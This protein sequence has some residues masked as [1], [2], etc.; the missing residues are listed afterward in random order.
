[1]K[2]R[3]R[4]RKPRAAKSRTIGEAPASSEVPK[5]A[6]GGDKAALPGRAI[7]PDRPD[8]PPIG[9]R[10]IPGKELKLSP[11]STFSKVLREELR[12][13]A[14]RRGLL[15][16]RDKDDDAKTAA[17][18]LTVEPESTAVL[19]NEDVS[20]KKARL[21]ALKGHVTGLSFSGGGIRAGTFAVGF[22]Q[23]LASL[24]LVRRLDYLSTVSGGGYAGA[25]LAA[26]LKR[27]GGDP[28]KV[29]RQLSTSRVDQARADRTLLAEDEVVEEEPQTLRH[30][31]SYSSYMIPQPGVFSVD[32][33]TIILI[34][35]R[36]VSINLLVLLPMAMLLVFLA[37]LAVH[38]FVHFDPV[39]YDVGPAYRWSAVALLAA[40]FLLLLM[41]LSVNAIQLREF[42]RSG[43]GTPGS[44]D[45]S[46][47]WRLVVRLESLL[48]RS[49]GSGDPAGSG[50]RARVASVIQWFVI[51]PG[52][53]AALL[54]T[55]TLR[56][57]VWAVGDSVSGPQL[58]PDPQLRFSIE[59]VIGDALRANLDI[60][61][62]S[63]F[64]LHAVVLGGFLAMGAA[65]GASEHLG[66]RRGIVVK[67]AL[68]GAALTLSLVIAHELIRLFGSPGWLVVD[69]IGGLPGWLVLGLPLVPLL[70]AMVVLGRRGRRF[71]EA[72]AAGGA[73]AGILLVLMEAWIKH[74][75]SIGR[76][77]LMATI[78][79]PLT[80]L[81]AVAALIVQVALLGRVIGES[82]RE[83]WA[84]IS[85]RLT[86]VAL[87]WLG[88]M[89][90]IIYLPGLLL[91]SGPAIRALIASGWLATAVVGVF[92]GRYALPKAE[93]DAA[94]RLTQLGSIAAQAFLVGLLGTVALVGSILLNMPGLFAPR[95]DALGPFA[96]YMEGVKGTSM[97]ALILLGLGSLILYLIARELID[98][99]LFSLNAMYANRLTR[100]YLGA[101]RPM[102][103]WKG[104][105]GGPRRD[106][107]APAGAPSLSVEAAASM[108]VRETNPIT[109]FDMEDDLDLGHLRIGRRTGPEQPYYGP[110]L[111]IN[112]T[113]NLVGSD[114]LAT[115]DRK[116]E[117]FTLSPLYCGSKG[118]GYAKLDESRR[119]EEVD[120]QLT[121]GRAIAISGAAVDPN[122]SFYQSAPL[123]ALLTL[124]NA[125]LGYWIEKPKASGWKAT[126]PRFSNLYI[127]EFFGRTD[128]HGEY[129][130]LSDGGHYENLGVYELIRR[131]CRYIILVDVED[132]WDASDDNL[133][134][135]IRLCRIDFGVQIRIDTGPL[136]ADGPDRLSRS[137]V[138]IGQVHYD[139]VDR[140]EM[141]GVLIYLKASMTGDEPPDLQKYA[142]KDDR[143]P[144]QP[145]DLEQSFNEEQFECY[146]CLG[147]HIARKVFED[148]ARSLMADLGREQLLDRRRDDP[149]GLPHVVYVPRLFSAIQNRWAE[150]SVD[151]LEQ[152][153]D[154]AHAWSEIKSDL[155]KLPELAELSHDLY[156]DL[157]GRSEEEPVVSLA[158][159]ERAELHTVARMLA[160]MESAWASLGLRENSSSPMNRGWMNTFR[161][162]AGTRA[163]RRLWPTLRPEFRSDFARFC[164]LQLNLGAA[165]PQAIRL[166][167]DN[168]SNPPVAGDFGEHGPAIALLAEEFEREW[169]ADVRD[170]RGLLDL[171][172]RA[173]DLKLNE[174][175]VWLIYQ[176]P[177]GP[178]M[179]GASPRRFACGIILAADFVDH[180]AR[181]DPEVCPPEMGS[182]IELLVWVRRPYRSVGLASRC[183]TKALIDG[184]LDEI[185]RSRTLP[186]SPHLWT[187]YPVPDPGEADIEHGNW[188]IFFAR[189]DFKPRFPKDRAGAWPC[190]LLVR[191]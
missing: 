173:R 37:R 162:W 15:D 117:S 36:N 54:L 175:P 22:L 28:T 110:H 79:P 102:S 156:P 31:R 25:W 69:A 86:L 39:E 2:E 46:R 9:P 190:S 77:D 85:A 189:F 147:E 142:R 3:R 154:A 48:R 145:T 11:P 101:S 41:A 155:G 26:W 51:V 187:R 68:A 126:S 160:V 118:V 75:A 27:E 107:R 180:P 164:E 114:D 177:S 16:D 100:C 55:L 105:W 136:K 113:L 186:E 78:S 90:T 23:G 45:Q 125:R 146:R 18:G 161:R 89:A 183:L 80:L 70:V 95:A 57:V 17:Q 58:A 81:I 19:D 169:P 88:G 13:L 181:N 67:L 50:Y 65:W 33:W 112:S 73:I 62:A 72:A 167:L 87:F 66:R 130:H 1:M 24:G 153:A 132:D 182:P 56:P 138:A 185:K 104:R 166:G 115:R 63:N 119:P 158:A 141:P 98:V 168:P 131:R 179:A 120:P 84:R 47:A 52:S 44:D 152:S 8:R 38:A 191:G 21:A 149:A 97:V 150:S 170:R 109:G 92:T 103:T 144:H 49:E 116:G 151:Q 43:S 10:T 59:K 148:P 165:I 123:T 20:L 42:R 129:I 32:T 137:H 134:N 94:L 96:Y 178:E 5:E 82:E 157:P 171:I 159:R 106:P 34:W 139:D 108:P 6:P 4:N 74:L 163:L 91:E 14:V 93:G 122:M 143:F 60:L 111:L 188:L 121:L 61:G 184:L 76:P 71:I 99:N 40:G 30:L 124:F 172:G 83:W 133:A 140:G 174:L 35:F 127:H 29:E 128:D 176:A 64:L 135:L 12:L 53:I 7:A